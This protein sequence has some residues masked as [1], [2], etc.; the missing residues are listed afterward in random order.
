M[1]VP[2]REIKVRSAREVAE[3][4]LAIVAVMG[5]AVAMETVGSSAT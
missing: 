5:K 2:G 1:S 3:R 4:A